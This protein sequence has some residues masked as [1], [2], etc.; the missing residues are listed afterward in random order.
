MSP[1]ITVLPLDHALPALRW[2]VA[3][4]APRR[5]CSVYARFKREAMLLGGQLLNV[6]PDCLIAVES[7]PFLDGTG[8]A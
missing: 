1:R 3:S 7:P 5:S 4:H 6:A 2:S 8:R